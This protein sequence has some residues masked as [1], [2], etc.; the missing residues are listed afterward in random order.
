MLFLRT[1]EILLWAHVASS[2]IKIKKNKKN[3]TKTVLTKIK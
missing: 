1:E 3:K 2:R